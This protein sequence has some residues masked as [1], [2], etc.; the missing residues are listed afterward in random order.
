MYRSSASA[1]PK[2]FNNHLVHDPP[3]HESSPDEPE[4]TAD[5]GDES[6]EGDGEDELDYPGSDSSTSLVRCTFLGQTRSCQLTPT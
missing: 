1:K 3:A 5:G 6:P 4:V 2:G